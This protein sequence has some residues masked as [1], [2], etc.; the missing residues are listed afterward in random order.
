MARQAWPTHYHQG[1]KYIVWETDNGWCWQ[2]VDFPRNHT[3]SGQAESK[4]QA[5]K[6]A[7]NAIDR[8]TG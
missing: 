7:R 8:M 5:T 2:L 1:Y 4:R 3:I 6:A